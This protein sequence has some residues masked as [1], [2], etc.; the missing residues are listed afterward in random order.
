MVRS[1]RTT[2]LTRIG[3]VTTMV[4]ASVALAAGTAEAAPRTI[5]WHMD[6]TSGNKMFD[7]TGNHAGT[8]QSPNLAT[9]FFGLQDGDPA[10]VTADAPHDYNF[11]GK[12]KVTIP[13]AADLNPKNDNVHI[14]FSMRTTFVPAV[15]DWDFVRK[16]TSPAPLFKIELMPNGQITCTYKGSSASA[17]IQAGPAVNDNVWHRVSCDKSSTAVTLTIDGKSFIKKKV[18]GSISNSANLIVASHGSSEFYQGAMDE[19]VYQIG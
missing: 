5:T 13:N 14:A 8:I 9:G 4:A 3:V 16:G 11:A 6:E 17:T 15:P 18:V 10:F 7:S 19:L 2:Y 1:K 12:S